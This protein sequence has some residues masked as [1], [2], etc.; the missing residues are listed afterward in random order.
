[1]EK[2]QKLRSNAVAGTVG[3]CLVQMPEISENT[4]LKD[5]IGTDSLAFLSC[6]WLN[7]F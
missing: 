3:Q 5:L 7:V 4:H 1:V 6:L 2:M